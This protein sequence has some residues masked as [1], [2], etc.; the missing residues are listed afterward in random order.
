MQITLKRRQFV[1]LLTAL[2]GLSVY[3][4]QRWELLP[5]ALSTKLLPTRQTTGISPTQMRSKAAVLDPATMRPS[6]ATNAEPAALPLEPLQSGGSFAILISVVASG[7]GA[8]ANGNT[9]IEGTLGQPILGLSSNGGYTLSGGF[10]IADSCPPLNI[11]TQPTNQVVNVGSN[12]TFS[13]ATSDTPPP[14]VQWQVST[15][16]GLNYSDLD[17]QT[18]ATLTLGSITASMN[19]QKYRAVFSNSCETATSEAATLAV[20]AAPGIN[21][22]TV[23]RQQGSNATLTTLAM[24]SDDLN[25]ASSLTVVVTSV[26]PGITIGLLTNANGAITANIGTDCTAALGN[27]IVGLKVTDSGGLA[28]T[29]TLIVN[30]TANSGP[31][32]SY[33]NQTI[34]PGTTLTI[35]PSTGPSDNGALQSIALQSVT[36]VT[37]LTLNVNNATGAVNVTGATIAQSYTVVIKATDQ[38]GVI[39][40]AAFTLT[41]TCPTLSLSPTVLP[42][43]AVNTAFSQTLTVSPAGGSY[44]FAVTAGALPPGLTLTSNGTLSGTPTVAGNYAFVITAGWGSCTKS[45]SYSLLITGTCTTITVNP[46]TLPN[47]TLGTAYPATN[48]SATGGGTY[49]FAVTQGTL[50]GG[51]AFNS[52]TGE[53]TGTPSATGTFSFRLTATGQGGCSGSRQYVISVA[54]NTFTFDPSTLSNG[55]KGVA[56]S[57]A[58]TVTPGIGHTFSLL[59]GSL[60]PGYTL[61]STGVLSGT[62]NQG[63]VW[64][65]TIK[66]VLGSCQGTKQ[67][68]LTIPNTSAQTA[69]AQMNDYDGDGQSDPAL[70]SANGEWR[71]QRSGEQQAQTVLWGTKGDLALGGDYDGDGRTDL[72]VFRPSEGTWYIKHSSN[73][74]AFTKTWGLATDIPVPSDYDGDGKTDLAVWRGVTGTWYIL[75]SSD[76]QAEVQAWGSAAAPY[77]DV[78]VPGDYDGDG[79]TDVAVFRRNNGVWLVKR[80]SDGQY[81]SKLWGLGTD[82]PVP[83]DYDGDGKTDFAVWRTG[84]WYI[85]QSATASYRVTEWGISK[86]PYFDQAIPG[87]YDGDGQTDVAVWRPANVSWYLS[88]SGLK[89]GNASRVVSF[90]QASERPVNVR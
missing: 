39:T 32:L 79:K 29:A 38:C 37:G 78:V 17:G 18:S 13:A 21:A 33:S 84:T 15:D 77:Q 19:G 1:L 5:A 27:N 14:T 42:N 83:G 72:A 34:V 54:C 81:V 55:A 26:P 8:S 51:L 30:V 60:P 71:I 82:V 90:G 68:T 45:Q 58:I 23:V 70:F 2:C 24:V 61:S 67:Y 62:T 65:F 66:A 12:A 57:Q 50:P 40:T 43:A 86:A 73:S 46:A 49:T 69:L 64:T 63:G 6:H 87:D 41:V 10:W 59:L 88:L 52:A 25:A 31:N 44:S 36:P 7:G 74:T 80:S 11:T 89:D 22:Q 75:R 9:G 28:T 20:N 3:A 47:G 16:G 35:T 76:G 48:V 85:W 53:L 56:Y 4:Q